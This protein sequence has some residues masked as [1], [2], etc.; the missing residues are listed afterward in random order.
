MFFLLH[1]LH[2]VNA[3]KIFPALAYHFMNYYSRKAGKKITGISDKVLKNM[4]AYSWPG[5]I[6]ELEHL[7]ER[8]VLLTK[9]TTIEDILLPPHSKKGPGFSG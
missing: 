5:N 7:V 4:M 2:C 3:K 1:C 9:G 6:R 8:S